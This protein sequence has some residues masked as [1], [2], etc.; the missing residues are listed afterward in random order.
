LEE[1]ERRCPVDSVSWTAKL[2]KEPESEMIAPETP[3]D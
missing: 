3:K 1:E 2:K